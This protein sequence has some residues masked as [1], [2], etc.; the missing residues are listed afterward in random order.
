MNAVHDGRSGDPLLALATVV[1]GIRTGIFSAEQKEVRSGHRLTEDLE[2]LD[3]FQ[4]A[5]VRTE[6]PEM[7]D[8]VL[9]VE[10]DPALDPLDRPIGKPRDSLRD[11]PCPIADPVFGQPVHVASSVD[12][13]AFDLAELG[14]EIRVGTQALRGM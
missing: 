2:G 9:A 6:I 8:H 7:S 12:V 13:D 11:Q 1:A 4:N 14:G 5:L 10:P 3:Q